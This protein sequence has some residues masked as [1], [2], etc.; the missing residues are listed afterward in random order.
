MEEHFV[1]V[2]M[3]QLWFVILMEVNLILAQYAIAFTGV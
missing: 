2:V 1:L 3:L